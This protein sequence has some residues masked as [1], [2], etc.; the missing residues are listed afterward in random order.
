MANGTFGYLTHSLGRVLDT[1][2]SKPME[3][4]TISVSLEETRKRENLASLDSNSNVIVYTE[5]RHSG[6]ERHLCVLVKYR[7]VQE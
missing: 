2:L 6:K 4:E 7:A 3:N 1:S 5:R